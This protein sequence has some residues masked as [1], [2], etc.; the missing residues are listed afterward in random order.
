[1]SPTILTYHHVADA[2]AD[3]PKPNLFVSP[4]DFRRQMAFL[5]KNHFHVASLD[6]IRL[7]LLRETRL[8]TRSVAVTFDD[9]FLDNFTNAFPVLK[10]HGFTAT[11]FMVTDKIRENNQ[12]K[13]NDGVDE[14][15]LSRDQLHRMA[16]EGITIG[17]H[18]RTHRKPANIPFEQAR[19]EII[20]SRTR[21]EQILNRPVRWFSY[22]SGSFNSQLAEFLPEAGYIGAASAIRDN[23]VKPHQLFYLPR[24]M[25]MNNTSLLRFRYFFSPLYHL[26]HQHKNKKRWGDFAR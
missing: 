18:S 14:Q 5:K 12:E 20:Q 21:L 10:Q 8:P 22:P 4:A 15:Y 1:M 7:H 3:H 13:N 24:V 6:M 25:V 23:R 2:P 19:E 17:S 9:G 11:I 16:D 26:I